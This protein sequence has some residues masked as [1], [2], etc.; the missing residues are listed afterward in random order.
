MHN[1][2]QK[3]I[4]DLGLSD[5]VSLCGFTTDINTK[6]LNSSIFAFTS[7]NKGFGLVL[8]EAMRRGLQAFT[9]A[10]PCGPKDIIEQGKSGFKFP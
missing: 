7:T 10:C 1:N 8:L 5:S 9:Y 6:M 4:E 2:L 3:Q